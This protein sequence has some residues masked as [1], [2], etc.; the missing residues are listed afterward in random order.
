MSSN[1]FYYIALVGVAFI[2]ITAA[3]IRRRM[4]Q[5]EAA[6]VHQQAHDR[7]YP[8]TAPTAATSP[9]QRQPPP[10]PGSATLAQRGP[11]ND[12]ELEQIAA[13]HGFQAASDVLSRQ[14]A[15]QRN[16]R[17]GDN[18]N[19][20]VAI[21]IPELPAYAAEDAPPKYEEIASTPAA[22][23]VQTIRPPSPVARPS[24]SADIP[25]VTASTA[26]ASNATN[27]TSTS[28]NPPPASN[29]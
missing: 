2:I 24:Q 27:T 11:L 20:T 29:A 25:S 16:R 6:R 22:Q 13:N 28:S 17:D 15:L 19:D 7:L 23:P 4:Q 26:T 3:V 21:D 12:Y 9:N 8:T 5:M 10:I 18:N 14:E 1:S